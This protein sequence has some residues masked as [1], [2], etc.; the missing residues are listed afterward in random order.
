MFAAR[1]NWRDSNAAPRSLAYGSMPAVD[2]RVTGGRRAIVLTYLVLGALAAM[3]IAVALAAGRD[4][5]PTP[6]ATGTYAA[7]G[8]A[9]G[10]LG[11]SFSVNQSGEFAKLDGT[12]EGGGSLRYRD[13]ALRGALACRHGGSADAVLEIHGPVDRRRLTGTIGAAS[14]A[15]T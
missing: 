4:E 10:C 13:G 1:S 14:F 15:A 7:I 11:T 9:A 6:N 3:A 8:P 2:S 5:D 12:G